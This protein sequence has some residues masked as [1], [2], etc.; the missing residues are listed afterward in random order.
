MFAGNINNVKVLYLRNPSKIVNIQF[1]TNIGSSDEALH[2]YGVAH[3]LEHMF[4]KGTLKRDAKKINHDADLIG[5]KINAWT[6]HDLTNYHLS[7]MSDNFEKGFELLSD[8]Y[9]NST[10]PE[11]EFDKEKTVIL[12][13]IR[14]YDDDPPTYLGD[15]SLNY[16]CEGGVGHKVSGT[17]ESVKKLSLNNLL[18]FKKQYYG[19][20]NVMISIVGDIDFSTVENAIKKYF[21]NFPCSPSTPLKTCNYRTGFLQLKKAE[22][23]ESQYQLIFPALP[24]LQPRAFI[25]NFMTYVLGG[26]SS[27]LLFER[28][29]E[30]LGLCYG[31]YSRVNYFEGFNYIDISTGCA[32]KDIETLHSEVLDIIVK[33]RKEKINSERL[34]M[35]K[36]AMLSSLFM[37]I[38]SS[39]GLNTFLALSYLKGEKEDII[40]KR[41]SQI[42][43]ITIEDIIE[44]ADFTFKSPSL[45]AQLTTA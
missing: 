41:V 19:G 25:Q 21:N 16:F 34:E 26:N 11:N 38:E 12:S 14:R 9:L 17:E 44:I 39:S 6:W 35:V 8:I 31:I 42:K 30:E 32:E 13:E 27:A 28:I 10:F 40:N 43:A 33:L 23:H 36:S 1:F 22:I 45:R 5:A 7:V 15:E 20:D 3:F 24:Y 18:T 37:S 4:F 29:R 2:E